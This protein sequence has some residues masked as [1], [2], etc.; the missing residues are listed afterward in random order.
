M[1]FELTTSEFTGP[2]EALLVLIEK[3]KLP[4]N[5]I[6]LTEVTDE[7]LN[8]VRSLNSDQTIPNRIHFV[9]VA[10]TLALIKSKSLLPNLDLT[11][12]EE[13]DIQKLKQRL[14]LY[15]QYQEIAKGLKIQWK[16]CK[17]FH[18]AKDRPQSISFQPHES[19]TTDN[20]L[21]SLQE[22]FKEVPLVPETKKEAYIKIAVHIEEVMDS[23][24]D[25]IKN[26][27]SLNFQSFI[28]SKRTQH[29]HPKQQKVYIVV[30]FL[31]LLEV[32]RNQGMNVSQSGLF[33]DITLLEN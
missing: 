19:I 33:S 31:A 4:I 6:S 23:L 22:V 21:S 5:D 27:T 26:Q 7:Y 13:T 20:L 24:L 17:Q 1:T 11:Q 10:S 15:G 18:F 16:D 30:S 12:E 3:R 14:Q 25:R 29:E 9:Y 28:K 32:V 8:F 2:I